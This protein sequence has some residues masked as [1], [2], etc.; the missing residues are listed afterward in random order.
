MWIGRR[1]D[2]AARAVL[3]LAR[4]DADELLT[5]DQLAA[6]TAVPRTVL[7][8]VMP[9]LR[10][11][12]IVRATR[13]RYGGYRLN[14]PAAE[15]TLEGVVRLFQGPLAPIAC[16]TRK[17][18]EPCEMQEGC[19]MRDVWSDVRDATIAALRRTTFQQLADDAGGAW[20]H[21]PATVP[22]AR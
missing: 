15:I 4:A 18:P 1:T 21:D 17:N 3:A 10:T 6:R 20:R 7:E 13:G 16:A 9:S 2:Y 12:G 14:K 19:S 22:G 5:L 11:A 8:Q